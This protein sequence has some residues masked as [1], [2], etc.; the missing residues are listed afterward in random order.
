MENV[1]LRFRIVYFTVIT[2]E[3][4]MYAMIPRHFYPKMD[5]FATASSLIVCNITI[6]ATALNVNKIS[7]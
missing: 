2:M 3:V 5:L 1:L 4:V 6:K 7:T